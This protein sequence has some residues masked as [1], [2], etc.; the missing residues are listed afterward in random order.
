MLIFLER[1]LVFGPGVINTA[2]RVGLWM[3]TEVFGG[4]SY[5]YD[6]ER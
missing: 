1:Y 3:I 4:N 2:L 6:E 5:G